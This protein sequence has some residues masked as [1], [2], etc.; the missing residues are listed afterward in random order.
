[1]I[2]EERVKLLKATEE[3][4]EEEDELTDERQL[5]IFKLGEEEYG[6]DIMQVKEIIRTT[7]ITKIPQVPSFVEGIIS[8]R[9]EILPIIDMRKKF[10]LPE[11][12]KTR[13][14]R[15]LVINL[16]N[17][18]IGGIV[19]EV[20]EV[21]RIPN[22]AITPPPPVIKGV[23]TEYLQGVGQINGRIIILLDMSKILTS[24]EIIQIEEL[25]EELMNK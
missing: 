10:S 2:D 24:N 4:F 22:D 17:M 19:D 20:T 8:L 7:N 15:I 13:Q 9:G 18:T 6:V 5:V 25:K 23:N 12:E 16:D 14:T 11:K 3:E 1:M 21:L